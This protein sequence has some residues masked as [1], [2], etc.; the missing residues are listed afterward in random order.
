MCLSTDDTGTQNQ[1]TFSELYSLTNDAQIVMGA[2]IL[3]WRW[4]IRWHLP[5]VERF[6]A[7]YF[8]SVTRLRTTHEIWH[9][10]PKHEELQGLRIDRTH[11]MK[12]ETFPFAKRYI[13]SN[14]RSGVLSCRAGLSFIFSDAPE[15]EVARLPPRVAVIL[16]LATDI[17]TVTIVATTK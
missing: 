13:T 9:L 12:V 4:I 8:G 17:P 16:L 1:V 10:I 11:A 2:V 14:L 5:R 15:V 7:G 3:L 6:A